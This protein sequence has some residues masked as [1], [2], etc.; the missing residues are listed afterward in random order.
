[1]SGSAGN[2]IYVRM[3]SRASAAEL[4]TVLYR[5]TTLSYGN[6]RFSGTC[7]AAETPQLINMKFCTIG[8][9]G[10]LRDVPKMIAVGWLEAAP[11]IGEI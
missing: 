3:K 7:H 2:E 4:S 1:M 11:Q 5:T 8:Y 9:V 6:M 10:E